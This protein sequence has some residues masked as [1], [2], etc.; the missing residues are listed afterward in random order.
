MSRP[1]PVTGP[2]LVALI[3]WTGGCGREEVVA[4]PTVDWARDACHVCDMIVSDDRFAAAVLVLP[5]DELAAPEPGMPFVCVGSTDDQMGASGACPAPACETTG[6]MTVRGVFTASDPR[7][8]GVPTL[9][10][11]MPPAP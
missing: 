9:R 5:T 6:T 11:E 10:V 8:D 7:W 4:P 1:W 3:L 2:A